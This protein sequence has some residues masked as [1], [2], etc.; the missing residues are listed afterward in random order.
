MEENFNR[1][2]TMKAWKNHTIEDIIFVI[3]NVM[4][5]TQPK[6]INSCWKKMCPAVVHDFT[7]FIPEPNKGIMKKIMDMG[8]KDEA[9]RFQ[10]MA[11]EVNRHHT[12]EMKRSPFDGDECF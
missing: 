5:V 11:L 7:R 3:E 1:Q 10:D 6:T 12:R 8:K 2:N 9:E 4:K